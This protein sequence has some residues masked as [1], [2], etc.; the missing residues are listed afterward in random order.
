MR[1]FTGIDL[2]EDVLERLER[3]LA[4]LRPTAHL[5]WSPVHNLHITTKFIG[6]WPEAKLE[7]LKSAL[8]TVPKRAPV[9]ITIEGLGWFPNPHRPRVF[10]AGVH[11]GGA[12]EDLAKDVERAMEPA[13]VALETRPYAPH[14]TLA[15]IGQPAP[16]TALQQAVAKL[17]SVEFGVFE[18][19]QF[20]L[21]LSQTGP[22]GSVYTK[23]AEFRFAA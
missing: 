21:Y 23:I 18:T 7:S 22:A 11:G 13:G 12:L 15:R 6:E 1:L 20:H 19:E 10:W 16:L 17:D 9:V 2:P 8:A 14:L 5:K 4:R 3:L